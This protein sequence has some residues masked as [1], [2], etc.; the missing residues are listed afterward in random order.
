MAGAV[1]ILAETHAASLRCLCDHLGEH[2]QGLA[3]AARRARRCG[4][5][6]NGLA[7]KLTN[8]D[9]AM[10]FIR[11]TTVPG[12]QGFLSTLREALAKATTRDADNNKLD[13]VMEDDEPGE[14]PGTGHTGT[15]APKDFEATKEQLEIEGTGGG[16]KEKDTNTTAAASAVAQG[17]AKQPPSTSMSKGKGEGECHNQKN[18]EE[19][20]TSPLA[21]REEAPPEDKDKGIDGD[22]CGDDSADMAE[23]LLAEE[24]A[25]A[26]SERTDLEHRK[27][28][29]ISQA[30]SSQMEAPCGHL[31]RVALAGMRG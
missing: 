11:H 25:A 4:I 7:K 6:D 5:L 23:A 27:R 15:A 8:L 22:L 17:A 16:A 24:T 30:L 3:I 14:R 20:A 9:L 26:E 2:H 19:R 31:L 18:A 28:K 29:A 1:G 13:E 21:H 10:A 12:A